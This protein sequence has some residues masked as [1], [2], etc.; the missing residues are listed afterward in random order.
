MA[1][2]IIENDVA[3]WGVGDTTDAAWADMERH[4]DTTENYTRD[5]FRCCEATDELI[6]EVEERGGAISWGQLP[7]GTRCTN[8]QEVEA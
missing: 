8:E 3:I 2:F 6:A 7:D 5:D 4:I 1:K